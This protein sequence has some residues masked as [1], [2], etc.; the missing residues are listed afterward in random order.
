[1]LL[2]KAKENLKI[3]KQMEFNDITMAIFQEPVHLLPV[4]WSK[5]KEGCTSPRIHEVNEVEKK[6]INVFH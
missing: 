5:I 4:P 3:T 1:V 6:L 2:K